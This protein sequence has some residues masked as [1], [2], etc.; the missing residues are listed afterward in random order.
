MKKRIGLNRRMKHSTESG[1]ASQG[2]AKFGNESWMA[3]GRRS[4]YKIGNIG[5]YGLK[6]LKRG[7]N[8]RQGVTAEL[9]AAGAV[10]PIASPLTTSSTRRLRWRPSAVSLED[11]GCVLP[12]PR[13]DIAL[14]ATPSSAR[15]SR[16]ESERRSES[17]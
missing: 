1:S 3:R 5:S 17:C 12:N 4:S 16:T 8:K 9:T 14:V 2:R 7:W 13:A 15:K 11:T 10:F 6:Q